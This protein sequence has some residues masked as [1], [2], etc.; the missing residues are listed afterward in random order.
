MGA[1]DLRMARPSAVR[2]TGSHAPLGGGR[3][4]HRSHQSQRDGAAARLASHP[5]ELGARGMEPWLSP[6]STFT[7]LVNI[8]PPNAGGRSGK[9]RRLHGHPAEA[10]DD[11]RLKDEAGRN[12]LRLEAKPLQQQHEERRIWQCQTA[13]EVGDKEHELPGGEVATGRGTDT[14]LS[15]ER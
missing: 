9:E 10:D 5:K 1:A 13:G 11:V 4:R 15:G 3:R 6:M 12:V 8:L 7:R 2:W 14:D